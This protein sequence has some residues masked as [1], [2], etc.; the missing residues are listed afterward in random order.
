MS[1]LKDKILSDIKAGNV[2]MRPRLVYAAQL[3]ALSVTAFLIVLTTVFIA[4]F[5]F[6]MLRASSHEALLG[7]G[8]SGVEVFLWHFPWGLALTNGALVLLFQWLF[9]KFKF[10]YLTPVAY[11]VLVL[12]LGAGVLG[13]AIDRA[14]SFNDHAFKV[15]GSLPP[16]LR[17]LYDDAPRHK[18]LN[19]ICQCT[20]VSI[21]GPVITAVEGTTTIKILLPPNSRRATTTGLSVGDTVFIAGE[22]GPDGIKAFGIKKIT[23]Y[24]ETP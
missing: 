16:P 20:I 9:R 18:R 10:G 6:F 22:D 23:S 7:F 21:D 3:V 5:V 12:V 11:T 15:R 17:A 19:G 4:N 8:M 13:F 2:A 24:E 14:T 1:T